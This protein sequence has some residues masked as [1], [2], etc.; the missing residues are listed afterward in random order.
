MR[1]RIFE[2]LFTASVTVT[3]SDARLEIAAKAALN[4]AT[5]AEY[6]YRSEVDYFVRDE[7]GT[8]VLKH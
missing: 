5:I 4:A 2:K 1:E 6:I 3:D 7:N 8:A